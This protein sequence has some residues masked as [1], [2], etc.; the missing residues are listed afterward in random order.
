MSNITIAKH[1]HQHHQFFNIAGHDVPGVNCPREWAFDACEYLCELYPNAAF[2][3]TYV[4]SA[5]QWWFRLISS[6]GRV[7]VSEVAAMFGGGGSNGYAEFVVD[8]GPRAPF[9]VGE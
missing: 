7:D 8:N 1:A 6:S 2:A 5:N 9:E 3:L 4:R